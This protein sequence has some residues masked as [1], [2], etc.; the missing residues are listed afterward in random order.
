MRYKWTKVGYELVTAKSGWWVL[1]DLL[2]DSIFFYKCLK[3]SKIKSK[4]RERKRRRKQWRE[5]AGMGRDRERKGAKERKTPPHLG[6]HKSMLWWPCV[7][8]PGAGLMRKLYTVS[9][10]FNNLN[11][12][13][14]CGTHHVQ[15]YL[16]EN[17]GNVSVCRGCQY[18]LSKLTPKRDHSRHKR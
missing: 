1:G 6:L 16:K 7:V 3:F 13:W 8:L 14:V 15:A 2:Y 9:K 10:H 12:I 17:R 5:G 4:R 18:F 11:Y